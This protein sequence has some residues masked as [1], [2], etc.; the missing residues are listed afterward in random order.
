MATITRLDLANTLKNRFGL[1][2]NDSYKMIDVKINAI[3][4]N[5]E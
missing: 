2:A 3:E 1:T 4:V 5:H